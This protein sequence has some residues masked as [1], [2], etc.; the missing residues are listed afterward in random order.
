MNTGD[1]GLARHAITCE[2]NIDWEKAKIVGREGRWTQR[3]FL[4]GIE[5]LQQKNKGIA[6]L[7]NYNQLEQW[8]STLYKC[9][10]N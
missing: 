5:F 3:K 7:N 8:Q 2:Q 10:G 1:G 4:K 6:P 9:F